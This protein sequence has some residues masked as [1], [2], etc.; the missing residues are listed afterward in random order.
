[1][2]KIHTLSQA[3]EIWTKIVQIQA[4]ELERDLLKAR[5]EKSNILV[6]KK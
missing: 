3:Q 4:E 1:M 5:K 6:N 2:Q